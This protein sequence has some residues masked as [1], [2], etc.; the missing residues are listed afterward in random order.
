[1]HIARWDGRVVIEF[2]Y[3]PPMIQPARCRDNQGGC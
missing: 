2:D 3:Y 1:M